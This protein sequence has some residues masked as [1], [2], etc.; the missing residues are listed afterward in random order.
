MY[1]LYRNFAAITT[2]PH[3]P[4]F[5]NK[6]MSTSAI[7]ERIAKKKKDIKTASCEDR[8]HDLRIMRPTRYQLRQRGITELLKLNG[9]I[10]AWFWS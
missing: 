10:Y 3:F 4:Q 7:L 9:S 1:C 8:T 5:I 2:N 6:E